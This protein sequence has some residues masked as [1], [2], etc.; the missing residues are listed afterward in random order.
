[1]KGGHS[2]PMTRLA[3]GGSAEFCPNDPVNMYGLEQDE[4]MNKRE[5]MKG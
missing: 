3:V 5:R 4:K 1:M 2:A